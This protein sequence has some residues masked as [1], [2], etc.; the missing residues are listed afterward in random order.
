M[1]S[2]GLERAEP[3]LRDVGSGIGG[4]VFARDLEVVGGFGPAETGGMDG[5]GSE[6]VAAH[7]EVAAAGDPLAVDAV[8]GLQV[9]EIAGQG[10]RQF[11]GLDRAAVRMR[12][13]QIAADEVGIGLGRRHERQGDLAA[14]QFGQADGVAEY[15]AA[16]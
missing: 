15:L 12:L 11:A 1:P 7:R 13:G 8:F 6:V 5:A 4:P 14:R 9:D 2:L 16:A 10:S 3:G